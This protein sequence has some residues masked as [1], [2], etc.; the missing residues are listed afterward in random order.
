MP[1][2][3]VK[4]CDDPEYCKSLDFAK[5]TLLEIEVAE[6]NGRLQGTALC[7]VVRARTRTD[8]GVWLETTH[9]AA[10]DEYYRWW[11]VNYREMSE[12]VHLCAKPRSSCR[13]L[14][15]R[16]T[17][18]HS[19][20]FRVLSSADLGGGV[21]KWL[22]QPEAA[23]DLEVYVKNKTPPKKQ[24]VAAASGGGFDW[25][26]DY[27]AGAAEGLDAAEVDAAGKALR[28]FAAKQGLP[29]ADGGGRQGKKAKRAERGPRDAD[30]DAS[31]RPKKSR[32]ERASSAK[33]KKKKKKKKDRGPF[34]EGVAMDLSDSSSD[35][36]SSLGSDSES[37]SLFRGGSSSGG[38]SQHL[39]LLSYSRSHPG[40]LASRLM[41]RMA[42]L[43]ATDADPTKSTKKSCAVM[44]YLSIL[45]PGFR[46]PASYRS[47]R[48]A[49]LLCTV[50]DLMQNGQIRS[51]QDYLAQ[52]LKAVEKSL[53][54][55]HWDLAQMIELVPPDG[56][57]LLDRSEAWAAAKEVELSTKMAVLSAPP[58]A[59][60]HQNNHQAH[61]GKGNYK[62]KGKDKGKK[63][64]GKQKDEKQGE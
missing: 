17:E 58:Q 1:Q 59:W 31:P 55:G 39:R 25:D 48:E 43:L 64:K 19:D 4:W 29:E 18:V 37:S 20:R 23:S 42:S 2:P 41:T 28:D 14:S 60:V 53:H 40:R 16:K 8:A 6:E 38:R 9:I 32:D 61:Q 46:A 44:Y 63:G 13:A 62:G 15:D 27:A 47:L 30:A 33:K 7:E 57:G 11:A 21:L 45:S 36:G 52:R 51:A 26:E 49:R 35:D 50:L 10:S 34:G 22:S 56:A 54:D 5:G 24:A 3:W 12:L